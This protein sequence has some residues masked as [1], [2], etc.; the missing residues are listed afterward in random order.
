MYLIYSGHH[1]SIETLIEKGADVQYKNRDGDT[2]LHMTAYYGNVIRNYFYI[3]LIDHLMIHI[4]IN[5]RS[6]EER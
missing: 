4:F 2:A 5:Y 6:R 1:H 3:H